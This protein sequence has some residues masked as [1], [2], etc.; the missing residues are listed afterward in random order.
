M[1]E[2]C[3]FEVMRFTIPISIYFCVSSD[4]KGDYDPQDIEHVNSMYKIN[5]Q[6]A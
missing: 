5:Y 3:R 2:S 6:L 1:S 4:P